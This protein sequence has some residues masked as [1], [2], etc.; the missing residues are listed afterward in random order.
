M[1]RIVRKLIFWAAATA[2]VRY[3][4]DPVEG[5]KRRADL[6][7][8]IKGLVGGRSSD[9]ARSMQNGSYSSPSHRAT[10]GLES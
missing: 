1:F 7:D 10:E 4:F 3:L 9:I 6:Q 8:Q 5:P 2:A